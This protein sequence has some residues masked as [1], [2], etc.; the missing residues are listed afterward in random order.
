MV[1]PKIISFIAR[2]KRRLEILDLLKEHGQSQVELMKLTKMY[3]SHI[4]RT[5]KELSIEK[6][7]IC[8]NPKD[9]SFRFYKITSLGKRV[10]ESS[11]KLIHR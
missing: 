4:S 11:K 7:I 8:K 1:S 9:R 3:K 2:S 10:L 5:L 6:L